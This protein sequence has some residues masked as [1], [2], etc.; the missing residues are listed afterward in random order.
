M[1]KKCK[2]NPY[3]KLIYYYLKLILSFLKFIP[4][5]KSCMNPSRLYVYDVIGMGKFNFF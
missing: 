3:E 4:L 5:N 1:I 2:F